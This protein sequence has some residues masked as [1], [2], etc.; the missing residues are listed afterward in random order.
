M[1]QLRVLVDTNVVIDWLNARQPWATEAKLL[2]ESRDSGLV[3]LYLPASVLTDVFYILR[4]PLGNDG[5]KK[6]IERC[7]ATCGLLPVDETI[8]RRALMLPGS[9]FEDNVHIACTLIYRIDLIVTRN[10][11]DFT[12]G[13]TMPVIGPKEIARYL[14]P[15]TTP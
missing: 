1:T 13:V 12:Q 2:W 11:S 10:P 14:P 8:I 15:P 9:D 3:E 6:A 7:V 4:K 5:A